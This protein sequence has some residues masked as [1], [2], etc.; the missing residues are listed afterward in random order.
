[1]L[2][3]ASILL[4]AGCSKEHGIGVSGEMSDSSSQDSKA[5]LSRQKDMAVGTSDKATVKMPASAL[6]VESMREMM[7]IEGFDSN[8]R[9]EIMKQAK[10]DG[11]S[12][13]RLS[14]N[15]LDN[16]F[17]TEKLLAVKNWD[18]VRA[19]YKKREEEG[20]L[21]PDVLLYKKNCVVLAEKKDMEAAERCLKKYSNATIAAAIIVAANTAESG[22]PINPN[23]SEIGEYLR[24]QTADAEFANLVETKIAADLQNASLRDPDAA[25]KAIR[26][27]LLE[28]QE[29]VYQAM[30]D[31]SL[32][33]IKSKTEKPTLDMASGKGIT[34][35]WAGSEYSNMNKGWSISE[36]GMVWFG[37]GKLSG[38]SYELALESNVSTNMT[39][40]K[41]LDSTDSTTT[42][43][44]KKAEVKVS[45]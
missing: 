18:D 2:M 15:Y 28:I 1:M 16:K 19:S 8:M 44:Q 33:T 21:A 29:D 39:K 22:W 30:S 27:S 13:M 11:F 42:T 45:Q 32:K 12:P 3:M 40:R 26:K 31:E 7:E 10:F 5:S 36:N 34:W 38:K 23:G 41:T 17:S 20:V 37:E 35:T 43:D 14:E 24:S 6:I 9:F 25:K 4:V